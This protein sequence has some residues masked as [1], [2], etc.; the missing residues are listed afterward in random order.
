MLI[1]IAPTYTTFNIIFTTAG[2]EYSYESDITE[3]HVLKL[4]FQSSLT[5]PETIKNISNSVPSPQAET[6]LLL[7]KECQLLWLVLMDNHMSLPPSLRQANN[8]KVRNIIIY[9]HNYI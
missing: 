1:V 9:I 8:M 2:T 7:R 3:C 5:H 4:F 6:L